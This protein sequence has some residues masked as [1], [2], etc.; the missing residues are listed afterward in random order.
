M[1]A[2]DQYIL[3]A[4]DGKGVLNSR[5]GIIAAYGGVEAE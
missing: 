2:V 1:H 3:L 4:L 5:V